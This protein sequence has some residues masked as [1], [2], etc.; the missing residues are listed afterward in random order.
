[1][2]VAEILAQLDE[3]A[4]QFT[5][6]MLDN[7]YIYPADVR[8]SIYRDT[9]DW[10]MVIEHL[11]VNP[12]T[13]SYGSFQN[14]LHLYGS[15]LHRPAGTANE[16][17]LEPVHPCPDD[18]I[19]TEEFE[20]YIRD[21]ASAVMIRD[22]RVTFDL[23]DENL[24]R[25]GIDVSD[26]P[27]DAVAVM[28]SLLPEHRNLLLASDE[29]LAM[30]NPQNIPLWLRLDEWNHPDLC[31]G[32][33]PSGSETFEMLAEAITSGDK[34]VYRPSKAPNTHWKN[35]PEGGTL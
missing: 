27:K 13:L 28:R 17:F 4:S 15:R 32:E 16:D 9:S 29:E 11:G 19:F 5:F 35:W 14:C 21:G 3:S 12:R 22:Q 26:S 20:W 30:R 8:M 1:M 31:R 6:P 34:T 18:W 2:T 7:G 10:L 25:K 23:S 24:K 33:K